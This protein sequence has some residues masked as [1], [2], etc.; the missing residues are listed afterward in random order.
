MVY[1]VCNQKLFQFFEHKLWPVITHQLFLE[2]KPCENVPPC[3]DGPGA[4]GAV[5]DVDLRP[6][7]VHIYNQQ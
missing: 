7:R 6:F 4:G 5:H 3:C 2:S 1:A